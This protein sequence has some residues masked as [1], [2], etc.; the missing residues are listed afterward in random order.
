MTETL[1]VDVVRQIVGSELA[2]QEAEALADWYAT[3]ARA[4]AAF[5]AADLKLVE[6]PLRAVAGP[7]P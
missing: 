4:V 3:F 5:P 1:S 6:P 7:M 2:E